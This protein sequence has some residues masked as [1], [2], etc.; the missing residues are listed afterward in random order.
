MGSKQTYEYLLTDQHSDPQRQL[1][2]LSAHLN[3][4]RV[5]YKP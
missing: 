5:Q 1:N 3:E 2:S 4:T